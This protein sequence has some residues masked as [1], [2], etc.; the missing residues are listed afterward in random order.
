MQ[1]QKI[2]KENEEFRKAKRI[3]D[4]FKELKRDLGI[5]NSKLINI[6]EMRANLQKIEAIK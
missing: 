4:E 2:R 6:Q 5:P 3:F 1:Y